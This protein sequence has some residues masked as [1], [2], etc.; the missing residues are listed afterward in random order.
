MAKKE[1]T[2]LMPMRIVVDGEFCFPTCS[3]YE[4]EYGGC[5]RFNVREFGDW[6]ERDGQ[7]R[8]KREPQCLELEKA[9]FDGFNPLV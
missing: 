7:G 3:F 9:A 4:R 6:H 5:T 8:V 1:F 2:V